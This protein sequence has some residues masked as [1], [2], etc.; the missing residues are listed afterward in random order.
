MN[1]Y[2]FYGAIGAALV[3]LALIFSYWLWRWLGPHEF[4]PFA[5]FKTQVLEAGEW[6]IR[7]H[8]SGRGP[9]LLLLHGIGANLFCWRWLIP[10]MHQNFTVTAIDLPGFGQSSKLLGAGYGLDDQTE[11]LGLVLDALKIRQTY[12]VGNSM[13]ANIGL[14]FA[15]KNPER[16]LSLALIA[17]ATSSK[18]MPFPLE[19]LAWLSGPAALMLS[20]QAMTWAHR[21]T[22]S[23]RDRVDKDRVEETF[24]TYGRS[25]GAVRSFMM[26]AAAIRD[27]RILLSL[28]DFKTKVLIL[29][30]SNDRL[31]NRKVIDDLETALPKAQSLV[32]VGGGHHLQED[33]P[34]WVAEKLTAFFQA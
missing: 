8:Q 16:T 15:L 4:I 24:A 13:G 30:G 7:Y 10:L 27:S 23:R 29:W 1:P 32:H 5:D 20:R 12:I 6:K 34:E 25:P 33:E 18:L 28:K 11:R 26:A 17:P 21:R 19:K 2:Y 31:V 9:H 3:L 14:W 22:V